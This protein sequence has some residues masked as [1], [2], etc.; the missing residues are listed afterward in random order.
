GVSAKA[1]AVTGLP[2]GAPVFAGG[3]DTESALLGSAV[4]ETGQLGAVL[5]TT[6]PVQLVIDRP[7]LDAECNL[8]TSP[9]VVADRWVLESNGG[10]TGRGYPLLLEL[11]FGGVDGV[12]PVR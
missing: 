10:D 8:G 4:H 2:E 1:A 12:A 11:V 7:L 3:A 6:T 9:H 5:G